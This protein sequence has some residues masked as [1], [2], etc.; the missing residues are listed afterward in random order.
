MAF[1]NSCGATLNEGAKFCNQCGAPIGGAPPTAAQPA[2]A[3]PPASGGGLK[4]VLIVIAVIVALG[5]VG[6]GAVSFIAYHAVKHAHVTQNGDDVK[7]ETPFGR[8]ETSKDPDEVVKNLGIDIY[9]GAQVK[10]DNAAI[11][12]VGSIRTVTASFS[13]EDSPDQVCSFYKSKFPK[14]TVSS[15]NEDGCTIVNNDQKNA[16]TISVEHGGSTTTF[17]IASV[18]K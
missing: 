6:I 17:Q 12:T 10:K 4:V 3:S 16:T 5:V 7:V 14:A 9:P 13:T 2:P 11:A 18:N 8:F 1:C 15:S